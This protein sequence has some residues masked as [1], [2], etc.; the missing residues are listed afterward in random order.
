[1]AT[2]QYV[3]AR[4]V[5]KFANPIEWSKDR[6]YEPLEMVTYLGSTYTSKKPVPQNVEIANTEYWVLSGNYNAQVETYRQAVDNLNSAVD[7]L[8]NKV[9]TSLIGEHSQILFVGF[10]G[11]EFSTINSALNKAKTMATDDTHRVS[12]AIC[13]GY[14]NEQLDMRE[15]PYIDL[16][17][18]GRVV[19]MYSPSVNSA[20]LILK[21]TIQV[22]NIYF[23]ANEGSGGCAV[24]IDTHTGGKYYDLSN[25][26]FWHR[27]DGNAFICAPYANDF[28][29]IDNTRIESVKGVP[30]TIH[31]SNLKPNENAQ[32]FFT[33]DIF[34]CH[35]Q[36]HDIVTAYDSG[37]A[38]GVVSCS[39]S[40]S[41][42]ARYGGV[43]TRANNTQYSY[44][45]RA[46]G[47]ILIDGSN[48]QILGCD[49]NNSQ[50]NYTGIHASNIN[51]TCCAC[52][53][54]ANNYEWSIISATNNNGDSL[55]GTAYVY[56]TTQWSVIV[57]GVTQNDVIN[58]T[59]LG[60]P[61]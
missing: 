55:A 16:Y 18:V 4:Y 11:S 1:M 24:M 40:G 26:E 52:V 2:R 20:T 56:G 44:I 57:A 53:A 51:G 36:G 15:Y 30:L 7:R 38:G 35:E 25:G 45:P 22:Q 33:N 43:H 46:G 29:D 59:L 10:A 19:V 61:K 60:V 9:N 21:D 5:P 58:L 13:G 54:E 34:V 41:W 39:F 27:G 50:L 6:A 14:Y 8:N 23:W 17:G 32:C 49:Y 47:V 37:N 28:I 48:T 3:G 42:R 12:I 31:N